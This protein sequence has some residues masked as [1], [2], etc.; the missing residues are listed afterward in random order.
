MKKMIIFFLVVM[1]LS[2]LL[3]NNLTTVDSPTAALLS[4]GEARIHQKIYRENGMLLGIDVGI[5]DAFQFGVSYGAENIV[6]E[7]EPNWHKFPAVNA[8]FRLIDET[9]VLPAFAI[10]IDT[11][12]HGAY[13]E[14]LKRYDIKSKGA[15]VVVSKNYAIMG[16]FGIDIGANYSFEEA[17]DDDLEFDFFAGAYKTFGSRITLLADVAVGLNDQNGENDPTDMI[18][19]RGRTYLNAAVQWNVTE[20]F[21]LKLL[22]HDLLK[23]K[24]ST[25]LFDR[26]IVLD[27]RWF[28]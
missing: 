28:F 1:I 3:S 17:I 19:G 12:G 23:N 16:L 18:S 14:D 25:E 15:Y 21:S 9:F 27:Y 22:M 4:A 10:G 24:R 2:P 8:K 26:S 7:K 20:Q 5:F 11:Q 13:H 6:G